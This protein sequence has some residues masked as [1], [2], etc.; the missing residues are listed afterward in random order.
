MH[1]PARVPE[2]VYIVAYTQVGESKVVP[3]PINWAQSVAQG[4]SARRIK[5]KFRQLGAVLAA[6]FCGGGDC[7]SLPPPACQRRAL[8]PS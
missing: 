7:D 5:C 8:G 3:R 2:C 6:F 4:N 1:C